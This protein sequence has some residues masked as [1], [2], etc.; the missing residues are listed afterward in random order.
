MAKVE[1]NAETRVC[2]AVTNQANRASLPLYTA[3]PK[4]PA[5]SVDIPGDGPYVSC[6]RTDRG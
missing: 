6:L 2:R 5:V 1:L 4:L 3:D